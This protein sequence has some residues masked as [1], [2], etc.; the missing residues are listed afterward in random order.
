MSESNLAILGKNQWR[1]KSHIEVI[2]V[3]FND[4]FKPPNDHGF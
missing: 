4:I 1:R 3:Y 2:K